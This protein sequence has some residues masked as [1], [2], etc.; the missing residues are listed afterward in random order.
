MEAN[1]V[2]LGSTWLDPALP[3]PMVALA[4]PTQG[5][6]GPWGLVKDSWLDV[7]LI[8]ALLRL[9]RVRVAAISPG[10]LSY[11]L[12]NHPSSLNH[13]PH[14]PA[15]PVSSPK[16]LW[17][18][19]PGLLSSNSVW[20]KAGIAPSTLRLG[21]FVAAGILL[22]VARYVWS[23]MSVLFYRKVCRVS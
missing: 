20:C 14:V 9:A 17:S 11:P 7:P 2:L 5:A 10:P 8:Q 18:T 21:C 22:P 1:L 3:L 12:T 19:S 15:P 6:G 13:I 4:M 16:D 23:N